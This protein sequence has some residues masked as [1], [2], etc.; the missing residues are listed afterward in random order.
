MAVKVRQH[1]GIPED[2]YLS[3][4][5]H[6][7]ENASVNLAVWLSNPVSTPMKSIYDRK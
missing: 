5:I 1:P 2:P 7:F 3:V 4:V 6:D